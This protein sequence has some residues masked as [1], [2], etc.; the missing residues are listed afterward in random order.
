M[1]GYT[2]VEEAALHLRD[3]LDAAD[4]DALDASPA[5]GCCGCGCWMADVRTLPSAVE[6]LDVY[7]YRPVDGAQWR[8]VPHHNN[9]YALIVQR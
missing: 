1:R 8:P 3:L 6:L 4:P 5:Q 9:L 2:A 7:G